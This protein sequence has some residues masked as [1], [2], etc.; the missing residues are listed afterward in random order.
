MKG[1]L[2]LLA[3]PSGGGK[4]SIIQLILS[5]E[6]E[7]FVYSV[8]T[9]TRQPRPNETDGADYYFVSEAEFK[10]GIKNNRFLEWEKVHRFYYGTDARLIKKYLES[11]KHVLFDLDVNGSLVIAEKFGSRAITIFIQPPS[12][13]ALTERLKKRNT[14]SEAEIEERM[15]RIPLEMKK[16]SEFDYIIVN[17]D[18]EETVDQVLR[19]VKDNEN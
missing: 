4:T 12:L 9:T 2:I 19:I 3:S 8:S 10:D 1:L 11:G 7:R 18:L 13:E 15:K 5:R 6:P 17:Q 16:S 14:D